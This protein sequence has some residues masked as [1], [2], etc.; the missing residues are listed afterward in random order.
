MYLTYSLNGLARQTALENLHNSKYRAINMVVKGKK[1]T[2]SEKN[3]RNRIDHEFCPGKFKRLRLCEKTN[4]HFY[5][6]E[7]SLL[8]LIY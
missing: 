5:M 4:N 2:N 3:R 1:A 8:K 6:K 7:E